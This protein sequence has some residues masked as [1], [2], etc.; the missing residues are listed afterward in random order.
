MYI[1]KN[2]GQTFATQTRFC[3][4]CGSAA[5]EEQVANYTPQP[6]PTVYAPAPEP[7]AYASAP[8]A[9]P[10]KSFLENTG[11]LGAILGF[12]SAFVAFMTMLFTFMSFAASGFASLPVSLSLFTIVVSVLSL[13]L[14]K[15]DDAAT[16]IGKVGSM[17]S[18]ITAMIGAGFFVLSSFTYLVYFIDRL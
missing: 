11:L 12:F 3:S 1:C 7:V 8:V 17:V 13:N 18:F 16:P 14:I 10:G 5:V 6:E 2:C 9:A 15:K 4:A